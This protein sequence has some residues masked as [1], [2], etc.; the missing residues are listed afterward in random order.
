V[1]IFR[2]LPGVHPGGLPVV[3][4]EVWADWHQV[5]HRMAITFRG[6]IRIDTGNPVSKAATRGLRR[7]ENAWRKCTSTQRV[8][9]NLA[10]RS[11]RAGAVSGNVRP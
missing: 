9:H 4:L 11:R 5:V 3:S 8:S 6:T 2:F 1:K 7:A 10:G